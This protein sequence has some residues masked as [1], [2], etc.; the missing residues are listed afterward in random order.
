MFC[1]PNQDEPTK[2]NNLK[3]KLGQ[4]WNECVTIKKIVSVP[5]QFLIYSGLMILHFSVLFINISRSRI[6]NNTDDKPG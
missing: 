1:P 2:S 4:N 6:Q 5:P 3:F